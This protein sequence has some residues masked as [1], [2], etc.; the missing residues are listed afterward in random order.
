MKPNYPKTN[1][2]ELTDEQLD[3]L[4]RENGQPFSEI[5]Q[6]A[7]QKNLRKKEKE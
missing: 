1:L 2:T 3:V 4:L 7:I 5:H 6:Q